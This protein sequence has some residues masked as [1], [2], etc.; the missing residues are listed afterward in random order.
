MKIKIELIEQGDGSWVI[1]SGPHGS[2][3]SNARTRPMPLRNANAAYL[4]LS[5]LLPTLARQVAYLAVRNMAEKYTP[6]LYV[7]V[8]E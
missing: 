7:T 2:H 4:A 8:D 6:P 5:D 3:V 1:E